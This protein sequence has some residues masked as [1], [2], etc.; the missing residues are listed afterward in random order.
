M[1]VRTKA[2]EKVKQ[3]EIKWHT[4]NQNKVERMKQGVQSN[5]GKARARV[6]SCHGWL[7]Q[8]V[9]VGKEHLGN[10]FD[11]SFRKPFLSLLQSYLRFGVFLIPNPP[12]PT[13][14]S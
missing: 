6:R 12:S 9:M 8:P 5:L 14:L 7:E 1:Y 2:E 3:E 11:I 13:I 4:A 10:Q